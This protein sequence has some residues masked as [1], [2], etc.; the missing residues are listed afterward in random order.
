MDED[1]QDPSNPDSTQQRLAA[2]RAGET[3]TGVLPRTAVLAVLAAIASI[4]A[5]VA[6]GIFIAKS[7]PGQAPP[8]QPS[9]TITSRSAPLP[10]ETFSVPNPEPSPA[11][12]A[13]QIS[14]D[15]VIISGHTIP[16]Q[17]IGATG[18]H[19]QI[20][21]HDA[22]LYE[23]QAQPGAERGAALIAAHVD[24]ADGGQGPFWPIHRLTPGETIIVLHQEQEH[25]YIVTE[26]SVHEQTQLPPELFDHAGDHVLHLMTCAGAA[27]DTDGPWR[28]ED[29]LIATAVPAP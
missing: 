5:L 28:Y 10:T 12:P 19:L 27:T 16:L 2:I 11:P 14:G 13:P 17:T 23:D 3:H 26:L 6:S 9:E 15:A 20:P 1:S 18:G 21:E 22:G 25:H 24:T 8:P 29:N 7:L 4:I